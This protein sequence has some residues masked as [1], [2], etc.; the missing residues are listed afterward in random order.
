M[1]VSDLGEHPPVG[2]FQYSEEKSHSVDDTGK[3]RH[4]RK[5]KVGSLFSSFSKVIFK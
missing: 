4:L 1:N 2:N 3:L 5:N